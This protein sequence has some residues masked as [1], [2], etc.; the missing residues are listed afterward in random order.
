M[1]VGAQLCQPTQSLVH[2]VDGKSRESSWG[3]RV[4]ADRDQ[5]SFECQ[6]GSPE[7]SLPFS[8]DLVDPRCPISTQDVAGRCLGFL[9][10]HILGDLSW[11]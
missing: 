3:T 8:G 1:M 11:L 4:M 5:P 7:D 2:R 9:L 10:H 6:S